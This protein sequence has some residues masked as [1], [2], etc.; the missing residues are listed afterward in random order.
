MSSASKKSQATPAPQ[1]ER[2]IYGFF[3][4]SFAIISFLL[5][6][7][8]SYLPNS[9][10]NKFGCDYLPDKYWSLA[11]PAYVI[12]IILSVVPIYTSMNIARSNNWDTK[13]NIMDEYTHSKESE[14]KNKRPGSIDPIYDIPLSDI[15][16]FLYSNK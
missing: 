14:T 3:L 13:D 4:L 2:A 15:C 12:V 9:W 7:I 16:Q 11:I 6:L 5:Y 1:P 8:V 10:L